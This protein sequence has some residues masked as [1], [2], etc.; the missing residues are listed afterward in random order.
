MKSDVKLNIATINAEIVP[1]E[2]DEKKILMRLYQDRI[3][4]TAKTALGLFVCA[5][6]VLFSRAAFVVPSIIN[7]VFLGGKDTWLVN[8]HFLSGSG[9]KI[10][11]AALL[12]VALVF[13]SYRNGARPFLRDATD[14]YKCKVPFRIMRKQYYP[15]TGQYMLQ[16]S[17]IREMVEVDSA[18]FDQCEEGGDLW[19]YRAVRCKYVFDPING[20]E[21]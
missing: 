20:F 21:Q 1:I 5:V 16:F 15:V 10:P 7:D 19:F 9:I 13:F 8:Q 6:V 3:R 14:G 4:G 18:T 11:I 12:V 2:D 17:R